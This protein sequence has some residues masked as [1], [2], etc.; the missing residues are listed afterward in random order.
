MTVYFDPAG[1]GAGFDIGT[2]PLVVNPYPPASAAAELRLLPGILAAG[3]PI[4]LD[5]PAPGHGKGP[6]AYLP[7]VVVA[8]YDATPIGRTP[9]DATKL[10]VR[11]YGATLGE[12]WRIWY[13]CKG[14]FHDGRSRTSHGIGVWHSSV[15]SV[16][17]DHDPLPP[18]GTGQ[19]C[20]YAIVNY[21]TT[22][23]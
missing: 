14:A 21:P 2:A 11:C 23:L 22:P 6:G 13:V 10:I 5:E 12:A 15:Q 1:F 20:I 3:I 9:I 7:F 16:T 18:V 8:L 17:P 19:P 4:D